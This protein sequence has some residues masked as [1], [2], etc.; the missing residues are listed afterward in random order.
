MEETEQIQSALEELFEGRKHLFITGRA[1][2]GKS[3]LL[4]QYRKNTQD[5]V[6]V[7]AP[8]GVAALNIEASTIHSVFRFS[9]NITLDEVAVGAH[10][11]P[12][13]KIFKSMKSLVIDEISMVRADIL[14]CIDVFLRTIRGKQ[15]PFGGVRLIC[16]GDLYQLPPVVSSDERHSFQSGY[17]TAYFFGSRVMHEILEN[18]NVN[19]K[20]IE[21]TKIFRQSESEFIDILNQI[22]ENKVSNQQLMKLNTRVGHI[23]PVEAIVLTGRRDQAKL[24]NDLHINSLPGSVKAYYGKAIGKF[25][26]NK[27][28]TEDVLVL[29]IGARVMMVAN[30]KDKRWVNGSLGTIT[31]VAEAG[32]D[33]KLDN[34]ISVVVTTY[35]WEM[36]VMKWNE[37]TENL[38]RVVVGEYRQLPLT[39]AAAVTIHKSQGKTFEQMVIDLEG[40]AFA[41]GQTYVALS[42]CKTLDGL[43]LKKPITPRD[44]MVD[45]SIESFLKAI[46]SE[47]LG[48]SFTQESWDI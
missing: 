11:H 41:H 23:A 43:F 37:L 9:P 16:F 2:T 47:S 7:V 48:T 22:R 12:A 17:R 33:V 18:G 21:L 29:K 36:S 35:S 44:I 1:G 19:F 3:T 20:M 42:R 8:T 27:F 14:D 39:V 26:S 34:G 31:K 6:I 46:D 4:S 25:E 13:K 40:G 5:Q 45:K 32:V 15:A 30:D 24:L 28:P 10:K 38:E